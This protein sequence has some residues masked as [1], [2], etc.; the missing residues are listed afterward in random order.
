VRH[1]AD[2][3][4]ENELALDQIF[5]WLLP[6]VLEMNAEDLQVGARNWST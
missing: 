1:L 6:K 5:S 3:K 2:L 4:Y